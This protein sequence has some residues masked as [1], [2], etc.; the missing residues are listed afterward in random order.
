MGRWAQRSRSGG[1]PPLQGPIQIQTAT[2]IGSIDIELTYDRDVTSVG[3][4]PQDYTTNASAQAGE[5]LSH[6]TPTQVQVT[7]PSPV[8]TDVSVT[9]TGAEPNVL[10]PQTVAY[11]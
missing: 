5:F 11:T 7:F 4:L 6:P 2:K 9:Y 8:D 3:F 1:G 10:T